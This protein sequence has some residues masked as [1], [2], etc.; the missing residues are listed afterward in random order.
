MYN[1]AFAYHTH[2]IMCHSYSISVACGNLE[3]D[4]WSWIKIMQFWYRTF[5][6]NFSPINVDDGSDIS[7]ETA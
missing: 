5:L 4:D 1:A 2:S 6:G 3:A 7:A